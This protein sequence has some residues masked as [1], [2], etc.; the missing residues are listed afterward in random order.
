MAE[1]TL[2]EWARHPVTGLGA[3]WNIVT[4]CAVVSPGC[5]NCYAMKLAGTR[6]KHH[7]S[8]QGLTVQT[9]SGPVWN[10]QVRFNEQWLTQPLAWKKPHGI[11]V[12]AHGDLFADGVTDD[13]LDRIFAIMA[14]T[15]QHVYYVLTKRPERMR[16]YLTRPAGNG[17][18]DIRNHL[19]WEV[20][21]Q[22]MIAW[23]PQ[24]KS[25]GIDGPHR[26]RGIAAFTKW[27][28]PNVWLGVSVEDQTRADERI[29]ILLDTPAALRFISAEPLLGPIDIAGYTFIFTHEDEAALMDERP[30]FVPILPFRDPKTT[31][32][33]QICTPRLDWVIAGGESGPSARPSH[34][35]WFRSLR[36]QCAEADVAFFFK[37]WGNWA[38]D[39]GPMPSGDPIMDGRARCAVWQGDR[40]LFAADGD[41][42]PSDA[43]EGEWVYHLG[44]KAAGRMLDGQAHSAFPDISPDTGGAR[45]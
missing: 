36:D 15:P 37:Q 1:H 25:E 14:L 28:L 21:P 13:Q 4:G 29:P 18:Q 22:V 16:D 35:D 10:G 7:V 20:L 30:G 23:A 8:R 34:P 12:A 42:P 45:T 19:A 32:S 33:D 38:P 40:W 39:T 11:F 31:P 17:K 41:T 26:S 24:W 27:P 5:T 2:I 6:L 44:K 43:G 3:T 9:K